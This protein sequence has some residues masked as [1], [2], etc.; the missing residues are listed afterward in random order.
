VSATFRHVITAKRRKVVFHDL[1]AS[2]L[3]NNGPQSR[4]T[5]SGSQVD[6]WTFT[7]QNTSAGNWDDFHILVTSFLGSPELRFPP[8]VTAGFGAPPAIAFAMT[9]G[10]DFRADLSDTMVKAVVPPGGTATFTADI[11]NLGGGAQDYHLKVEA[12]LAPEPQSFALL[13]LGMAGIFLTYRVRIR[14]V[15]WRN[16]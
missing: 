5:G 4:I 2:G 15:K 9:A 7:I 12:T 16:C 13:G 8:S 1:F 11:I 10:N 14:K 6:T 3:D